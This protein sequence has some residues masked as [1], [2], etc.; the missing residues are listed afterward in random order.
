[1]RQPEVPSEHGGKRLFSLGRALGLGVLV[2]LT[3]GCLKANVT[4]E[5]HEDGSATIVESVV[6]TPQLLDL[7][8]HNPEG[9]KLAPLLNRERAIACSRLFGKGTT[10]VSHE[11]TEGSDGSRGC[12][13]VYKIPRIDDLR[14]VNPYLHGGPPGRLLKLAFTPFYSRNRG[15]VGKIQLGLTEAEPTG[16][17]GRRPE[18]PPPE[19]SPAELQV[20][21]ELKPVI[22][23][24]L[25]DLEI[26]YRLKT[27]RPLH[28]AYVRDAGTATRTLCLLS[29]SHED[30]DKYG[31]KFIE[32]EELMLSLLRFRFDAEN[33]ADHTGNF[34]R[35]K[36]TPVFRAARATRRRICIKP[37]KYLFDKYFAG[38]PKSQGG[39]Q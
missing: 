10:L 21:R 9:Q 22:A 15:P 1:M 11:L 16:R 38:R 3:C 39:D 30:L 5:M 25:K 4:V 8:R 14:L 32:N 6:F 35:N 2:L 27:A 29:F 28:E 26:V 19:P 7:D 33:L 13:V 31:G 34:A 23:D 18:T 36:T 20:L 12:E 17:A 24:M 37:T